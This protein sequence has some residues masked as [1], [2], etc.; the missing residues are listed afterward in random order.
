MCYYIDMA[1]KTEET[2][3]PPYRTLHRSSTNKVVAGVAGGLGEYF[4]VDPTIIRIAFILLSVFGGSGILIYL[5]LW[6]IMPKTDSTGLPKDHL[7][8]SVN[9]MRDSFKGFAEDIKSGSNMGERRKWLGIVIL[10]LG[11]AAL[12]DSFGFGFSEGNKL[13][14]IILIVLG[15]IALSRR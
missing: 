12:F 10:V 9:E 15:L 3:Q 14:P 1:K 8:N 2:S 5:V 6:L 7:R 4:D 13:W 11:L